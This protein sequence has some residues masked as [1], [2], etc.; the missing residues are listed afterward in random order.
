MKLPLK[1][2][3]IAAQKLKNAHWET[4]ELDYTLSLILV[5]IARHPL[6]AK[7]LIFKG[8][9]ALKKCYFGSQYRF[10][11]DLDFTLVGDL[12]NTDLDQIIIEITKQAGNVANSY[13]QNI[14]FTVKT[15]R[16]QE[17][18]PHD[19]Q[20]YIIKVQ[21]PWHSQPLTK[22]KLEISRDEL[23]LK[24]TVLRNIMHEYGEHVKEQLPVYALEEILAEKYR[25]L[26]QNQQKLQQKTWIRS[27]VRDFYDLWHILE[28]FR[29]EL[30]LTNFQNL[31]VQKCRYKGIEFS[32]PDQFF[33][34]NYLQRIKPDW[35]Q[36]LSALIENLPEFDELVN[37]LKVLTAEVFLGKK[38]G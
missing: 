7:S 26:L 30:D 5:A 12:S 11:Q 38:N 4:I 8:G 29:D 35:Q 20:A 10:S 27:R 19:Q 34:P 3:L 33:A 28:Q 13:D 22:I 2:R 23:I 25:G 9:T 36:F 31:V 1:S 37:K 21:L 32:D 18:H 24:P 16:E 15:Y 14:S 17:P 6:A